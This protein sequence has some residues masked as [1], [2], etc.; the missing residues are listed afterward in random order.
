MPA[1]AGLVTRLLAQLREGNQE[2]ANQP[3]PLVYGVLRRMAAA[4]LPCERPGHTLQATVLVNDAYIRLVGGDRPQWQN[5]AHSFAIA[6]HTIRQVSVEYARRRHAGKR[7]GTD[8][9]KVDI[10]AEL[11]IAERNLDD[12]MVIDEVLE[13]LALVDPQPT[14]LIEWRFFAGMNLEEAADMGLS[15]STLKR[16]WRLAK[17]W[18]SRELSPAKSG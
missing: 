6:A 2:A 8:V 13:P 4:Y 10:Y 3:V 1:P 17:A 18:L 12:V 15:S 5:R 7:G 16:E 9:R 11:F 14:R